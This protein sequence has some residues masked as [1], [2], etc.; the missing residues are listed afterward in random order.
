MEKVVE[1]FK[2]RMGRHT[3]L[4]MDALASHPAIG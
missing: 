1:K 3:Q 2:K 4:F